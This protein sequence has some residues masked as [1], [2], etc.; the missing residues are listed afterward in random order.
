MMTDFGL[1]DRVCQEWELMM[2]RCL[3]WHF[4]VEGNFERKKLSD[5]G[6]EA[7]CDEQVED[8]A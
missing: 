8:D 2:L 7:D 1:G 4:G 3:Q 5:Y 6:E